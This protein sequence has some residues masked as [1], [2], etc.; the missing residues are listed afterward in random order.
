MGPLWRMDFFSKAV[1]THF[2]SFTCGKNSPNNPNKFKQ[3]NTFYSIILCYLKIKYVINIPWSY[4]IVNFLYEEFG[5]QYHVF[6]QHKSGSGSCKPSSGSFC[7]FLLK[8]KL[9]SRRICTI[10]GTIC[11]H[12][13]LGFQRVGAAVTCLLS[14][15]YHDESTSHPFTII[16]TW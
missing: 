8:Q 6:I 12:L 13:V 5:C 1:P 10:C 15:T 4:F 7:C 2:K 3:T 9:L 11:G 16:H 14:N